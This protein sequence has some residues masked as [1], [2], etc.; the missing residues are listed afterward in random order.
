MAKA[1]P[2]VTV[3]RR[4]GYLE[5]GE[6]F[7]DEVRRV[8]A[9]SLGDDAIF[10]GGLM[11]R[12]TVDPELQKLATKTFR[13][14]LINY[15]RRHGYRPTGIAIDL[16]GNY[17]EDL[18][19]AELPKG[20]EDS[21]VKAVVVAVD[22]NKATVETIDGKKGEISVKSLAWARKTLKD[23]KVSLSPKKASENAL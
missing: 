20:A 5:D 22:S 3:D 2:L 6:Y 12:T 19:A 4:F 13:Q 8:L 10:E 9:K 16:N 15:D 23:Q 1:K 17:K 18:L 11:V 21:W 14:G 7:S